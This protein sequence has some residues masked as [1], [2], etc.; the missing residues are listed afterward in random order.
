[1][2]SATFYH[3]HFTSTLE[4]TGP[5]ADP[6]PIVFETTEDPTINNLTRNDINCDK[7]GTC[8][9]G[10]DFNSNLHSA[11]MSKRYLNL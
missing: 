11:K 10:N 1:M 8:Y 9:D 3:T 6:L 7:T 2:C 4:S 5:L